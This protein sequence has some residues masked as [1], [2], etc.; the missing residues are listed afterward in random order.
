MN[1]NFTI[2]SE[3]DG[4]YFLSSALRNRTTTRNNSTASAHELY[5]LGTIVF[6]LV[7]SD[8]E[9]VP[10][11]VPGVA[12][13]GVGDGEVPGCSPGVVAG[14]AGDTLPGVVVSVGGL[15][16]VVAGG[17]ALGVSTGVV[18]VVAGGALD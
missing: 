12:G 2:L 8:P 13:G 9:G 14:G 18:V 15:G 16:D 10:V 6:E 7:S 4:Q 11:V 1:R 17:V 3:S 5:M